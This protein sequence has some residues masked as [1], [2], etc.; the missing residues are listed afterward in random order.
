MVL[1]GTI[2]ASVNNVFPEFEDDGLLTISIGRYGV[3]VFLQGYAFAVIVISE[4]FSRKV[5]KQ[6][7]EDG[8]DVSSVYVVL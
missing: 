5:T 4:F 1:G 2:V 7:G 3:D 6:S 8:N